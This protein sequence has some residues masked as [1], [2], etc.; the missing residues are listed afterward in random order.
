MI[1][2]LLAILVGLLR[3]RPTSRPATAP[4]STAEHSHLMDSRIQIVAIAV[5]AG[6]FG[7]S[8]SWCGAGG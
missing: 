4:R 2:V 6:L 8:S 3:A 5:T 7:S 1:K